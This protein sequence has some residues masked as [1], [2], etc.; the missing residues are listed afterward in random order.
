MSTAQAA[1]HTF[2]TGRAQSKEKIS[3]TSAS[4]WQG[5]DVTHGPQ[6]SLARRGT[7]VGAEQSSRAEQ[8][9]AASVQG[10]AEACPG[11]TTRDDVKVA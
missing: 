9:S 8:S 4:K 10:E 11:S 3:R 7:P 2:T 1:L 6:S 5:S